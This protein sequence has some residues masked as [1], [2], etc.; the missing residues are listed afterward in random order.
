MSEGFHAKMSLLALRKS[1][2]AL[3]Y[4]EESVVPMRTTLPSK[5]LGSTRT[6]LTP[7]MDSKD[8]SDRLESGASSVVP[9]LMTVSSSKAINAEACSQHSTSHS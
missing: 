8:P 7:S 6:S 5:L 2:S 9:S 3:S 1:V 4:S